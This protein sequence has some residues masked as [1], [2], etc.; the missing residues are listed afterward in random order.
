MQ[1]LAPPPPADDRAALMDDIRGLIP[2]SD[3][4]LNTGNTLFMGRTPI[5][6]IGT[7]D[8]QRLREVVGAIKY[9]QFS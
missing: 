9:G 1:Q 3:L 5:D 8:E 4:W 2:H 6:L 7:E